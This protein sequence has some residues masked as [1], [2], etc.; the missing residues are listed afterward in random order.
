M[1]TKR[2]F[3]FVFFILVLT[4]LILSNSFNAKEYKISSK[5][6]EKL[7]DDGKVA[8]YVHL[9]DGS[10][11]N[12]G[13][14]RKND[15]DI[16]IRHK[17][18]NSISA[19]L[20]RSEI[21]ALSADSNVESIELIGYKNIFLQDS[22]PLVNATNIWDKQFN[23]L[24]ITGKGQTVCVID[25][26]V[27]YTHPD[28]GGCYGDN[29]ASSS[30]KIIGGYD[31]VNSDS[32]PMDDHGHGTHVAGIVAANGSITGVAPE[33]K[34]IAIK[35]CNS[36][37]TCAED[38]IRAGIDW[39]VGNSSNYNISVISMSLGSGLYSSSCDYQD[40]DFNITLGINNAV[41]KNISVVISAG[42]GLNNVGSGRANQIASPACIQNATSI[43]SVNKSDS[44]DVS[45]ADR[46]QLVLLVAPGTLINSTWIDGSYAIGTGTSMA[47]PHVSGA[48]ALMRQ[49]LTLTNKTRTPE[50][51]EDTLNNTG[52]KIVDPN[53]SAVANYSRINVYDAIISL[54]T[55]SPN[56]TLISPANGTTSIGTNQTF[57]CNATDL[58]LKNMTFY[59]WN[60]TGIYNETFSNVSGSYNNFEINITN[61]TYGDY[62]WNC[63]YYDENNNLGYY[64]NNTFSYLGIEVNLISPADNLFTKENQT[65]NCSVDSSNG[66]ANITLYL[67][68]SSS[69]EYNLTNNVSGISNSSSFDF[70]FTHEGNYVWNCLGF[71][72]LSNSSFA[73]SNYSLTYDL[74]VPNITLIS[75]ADG[76]S[77]TGTQTINFE[78]N[79]SDNF[80]ISSCSL[81]FDN[82]IVEYNSSVI[83]INSSNTISHQ[84]GTGTYNWNINCTDKSGN[85]GNSSSRSFTINPAS[86]GG[87]HGGGGGG[88]GGSTT[89]QSYSITNE[90]ISSGYTQNLGVNSS[91]RFSLINN[92]SIFNHNI[93]FEGVNN[94]NRALIMIRSNPIEI[95]LNI[96]E[97]RKLSLD[98]LDKYNLYIK[99]NS[100]DFGKANLTIRQIDEPIV[101]SQSEVE[102]ETTNISIGTI[103]NE[104]INLKKGFNYYLIASTTIIAIILLYIWIKRPKKVQHKHEHRK[105]IKN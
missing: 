101:I 44:I 24:N 35:V 59:L 4:V 97:E 104:K 73:S 69:L 37:G 56:V 63:V 43:S 2:G 74:T 93:T 102:N 60:S 51:I 90:Q 58:A 54:D 70:N 53:E 105:S 6:Q 16:K 41:G 5:V 72:N 27:N 29:D 1:K 80:N 89:T 79:V 68:N 66:L 62:S 61:I 81:L 76:Y 38:H 25:T 45:Y 85:I 11:L 22:V 71:N 19:D 75:P 13:I 91:I 86:D 12:K 64:S 32:D 49:Y 95:F 23:A 42:N 57:K 92:G 14:S 67:W 96:G 8:V 82:S 50:E 3:A 83:S 39:C 28:L 9:K 94:N 48:I 33:A 47:A 36:G 84:I 98:S 30:C 78:F 26:G 7:I 88:G 77:T 40:D 31:F 65:F 21:E 18:E 87:S 20:T 15:L 52:K 55:D 17:F 10:E 34:I 100:I 46:N 103:N 99:L